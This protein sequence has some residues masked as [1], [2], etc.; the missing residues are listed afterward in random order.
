MVMF[1]CVDKTLKKAGIRPNQVL[2]QIW[3]RQQVSSFRRD[4]HCIR[5]YLRLKYR[6]STLTLPIDQESNEANPSAHKEKRLH[7]E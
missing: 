2:V 7:C 3:I 5:H 4:R 6:G 1:D